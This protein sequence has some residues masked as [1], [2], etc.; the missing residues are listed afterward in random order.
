MLGKAIRDLGWSRS[1]LV[2]S[3][4]L[5]PRSHPIEKGPN[6]KGLHRK[7]VVEGLQVSNEIP[8]KAIELTL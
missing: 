3:T 8:D 1:S 5:L 2:I 6:E 7:H 4:K